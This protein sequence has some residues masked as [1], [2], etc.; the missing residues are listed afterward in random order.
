MNRVTEIL[1]VKYP[2]IQAPM[3][4]LTN[5]RLAAA[6]SNAGGLGIIGMNAGQATIATDPK[7]VAERSRTEIRKTRKLTNKPFGI[8]IVSSHDI[9]PFTEE[10]LNVAFEENIKIFA[11][12]DKPDERIYS[13]IKKHGGIIIARP[14]TPMAESLQKA[15]EFGADIV[16]AT[17]FD[18]GG[19]LGTRK[20]G[21]MTVI[22]H[23]V[24]AVNVPVIAAGGINDR[25]S[26]KAAI[27]LGAEGLYI[28]T[29]FLV[30]EEAP[31]AELVKKLIVD[32]TNEDLIF[33]SNNQRAI[34]TEFA[35]QVASQYQQ[36]HDGNKANAIIS[37]QGGLRGAMLEGKI[38]Q[39]IIS[40]NTGIEQIKSISSV[41][42]IVDELMKG[43]NND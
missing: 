7:E 39:G 15:V 6:V 36:D 40:V 12:V 8:N 5:A 26:A 10:T 20:E 3:N 37:E 1:N 35:K 17:S 33:V 38:N 24:Q 32:S 2:I 4:W 11:L 25:D 31:T 27:D 41:K 23:A 42:T 28:G 14:L 9:N 43:V 22:P 21:S 30:S 13:L 34:K 19:I 16:V 18:E 29:R